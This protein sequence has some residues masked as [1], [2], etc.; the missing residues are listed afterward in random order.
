MQ[1]VKL[2]KALRT[3]LIIKGPGLVSKQ[4]L[5][6]ALELNIKLDS[7]DGFAN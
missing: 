3:S 6:K 7:S 4:R 1:D 5:L 2:D